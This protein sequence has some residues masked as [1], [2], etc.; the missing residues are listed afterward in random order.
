LSV[1][2]QAYLLDWEQPKKALLYL[3]EAIELFAQFA[4]HAPQVYDEQLGYTRHLLKQAQN[5]E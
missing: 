2:G 5:A 3:K 4:K 1:F